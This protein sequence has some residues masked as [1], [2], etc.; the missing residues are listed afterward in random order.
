MDGKKE[1]CGVSKNEKMKL[2]N[3]VQWKGHCKHSMLNIA[4]QLR[5]QAFAIQLPKKNVS[6]VTKVWTENYQN[7]SRSY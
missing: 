5:N 4:F 2:Q 1:L 7:I 6:D 3:V